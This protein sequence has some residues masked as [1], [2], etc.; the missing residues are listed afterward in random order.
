MSQAVP[1]HDQGMDYGD[2]H[3]HDNDDHHDRD[4]GNHFSLFYI[5]FIL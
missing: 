4:G 1:W 3:D 5:N 2:D